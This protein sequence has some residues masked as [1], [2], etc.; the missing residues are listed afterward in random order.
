MKRLFIT[1]LIPFLMVS[2]LLFAADQTPTQKPEA[3]PAVPSFSGN[4]VMKFDKMVIDF[5]EAEAGKTVD[6]EFKFENA[7]KETLVISNISTSCG[8]TAVKS[9]KNEY[10]PGEKGTLPVKFNTQGYTGAVSKSIT[11][12]INNKDNPYVRLE[13]KGNI[14][15]T[16]F[17]T[18]EMAKDADRID[19][20]NAKVGQTYTNK[21]KVKNSGSVPLRF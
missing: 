20:Q 18:L 6:A 13:L 2:T 16:Q 12:T 3:K 19:F 21:I 4:A 8:C 14:K 5:G 10:K 9:E 15:V 1:L 17:A 7:G 11:V